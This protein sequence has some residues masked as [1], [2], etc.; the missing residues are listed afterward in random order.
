MF[1]PSSGGCDPCT[2][3][4]RAASTLSTALS[5]G[6]AAC[7]GSGGPS[8]Y[9]LSSKA[10]QFSVNVLWQQGPMCSQ[11]GVLEQMACVAMK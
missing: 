11:N 2:A 7:S 4:R 8:A 3:A 9:P 6:V 10:W 1:A 5:L